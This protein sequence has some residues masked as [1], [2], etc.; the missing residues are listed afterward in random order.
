MLSSSQHAPA[1]LART[2]LSRGFCTAGDSLALAPI[3]VGH[4]DE[5]FGYRRPG[6]AFL[7]H[8]SFGAVPRPVRERQDAL[9][10]DWLA[11][12][13][14]WYFSGRLHDE[15]SAAAAAVA[16]HVHAAPEEVC[17]LGNATD[18]CCTL[19]ARWGRSLQAEAGAGSTGPSPSTGHKK[20]MLLNMAYKANHYIMQHYVGPSAE[21]VFAE[22]PFPLSTTD[23]CLAA[24]DQALATH[25]PEYVLLE[26]IVSQPAIVMP[27][28]EMVA[29]CREHGVKEVAVDGAH[30]YCWFLPLSLSLFAL[31]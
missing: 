7:N 14:E 2:A 27:V 11:Y 5:D 24:L 17:L 31:N 4:V 10:N 23:Q 9:R 13:D 16:G 22:M 12:P 26:H 8:A 30:R 21:V 1:R 15:M 20:V 29:L 28:R 6:V 25:R 19:A 18:A 3:K